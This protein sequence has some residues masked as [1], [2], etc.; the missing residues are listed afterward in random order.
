MTKYDPPLNYP[1]NLIGSRSKLEPIKLTFEVLNAV[2]ECA[3]LH[4]ESGDWNEKEAI[5]YVSAHGINKLGSQKIISH[6]NN[7]MTY[8]LYDHEKTSAEKTVIQVDQVKQPQQYKFWEGGPYWKSNL[9]LN[10]FVDVLM[11]LLF[12]GI[13]KSTR[14]LVYNWISQNKRLKGY[15][16]FANHI[17]KHIA[18]MGLD[19]C[20]L[21]VATSGWVSD[22]YIAFAR[23]CKWFYYPIIVLHRKE[24]Y[25]ES[26]I[27]V[28]QWYAK[29]CKDWMAAHGYDTDGTVNE[30]KDRILALKNDTL[31][32]P[33]LLEHESC[34]AQQILDLI[35]SLLSMV[36]S[37]MKHEVSNVTID[38]IEREI[39]LFLTNLHIVQDKIYSEEANKEDTSTKPYWL[40]KYNHLSLLNIPKTM[41]LF[42]PMINLW[43]GSNQ[44]EGYLRF[45]K[46][47]LTNIHSKNWNINAHCEMLKQMSLDEVIESHVNNNYTTEKCHRFLKYKNSRMDRKKKMYMKYKSVSDIFSLFRKNRPL[48]AVRCLDGKYYAV[49]QKVQGKLEAITMKLN[50]YITLT[51]LSMTYYKVLLDLSVTDLEL[52][53]FKEDT[54]K[55]YLLLLPELGKDGYIS[56]EKN[57]SYHIIDS[58]WNELND[59]NTFMPPKTPGCIY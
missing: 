26:S 14:E 41:K 25:K 55:N 35:G 54:I 56:I 52:L 33:Q 16:I 29:I 46:P 13:T 50:Y 17:F 4:Y 49:I 40:K 28:K 45:A 8:E 6:C 22:N 9:N 53:P 51:D 23:I 7:K 32:P 47:K 44:G 57:A 38:V 18:D 15:K 24:S 42:G 37:I 48:S 34:S 12:L 43:E 39:K 21:L 36:S 10:Q 31:S 20:K 27:P 59:S 5:T 30:L 58:E 19:W 3:S 11:H 2:I 1:T